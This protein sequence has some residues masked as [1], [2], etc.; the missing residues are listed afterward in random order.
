MASFTLIYAGEISPAVSV[1]KFLREQHDNERNARL[2]QIAQAKKSL[3]ELDT[4]VDLEKLKDVVVEMQKLVKPAA[5]ERQCRAIADTIKLSSLVDIGD[6]SGEPALDE[7]EIRVIALSDKHRRSLL[8]AISDAYDSLDNSVAASDK[9]NAAIG[10]FVKAAVKQVKVGG[11]VLDE[12]NDSDIDA[13]INGGFLFQVYLVA[14]DY[15][16]MSVLK[17]NRFG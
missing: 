7:I 12:P 10:E 5:I 2:E 14:R 16:R 1:G 15:Q 8:G 17:K 11:K 3:A 6:Y 4:G 9:K 13:M